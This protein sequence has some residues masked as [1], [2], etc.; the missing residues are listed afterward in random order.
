[1]RFAE[2]ISRHA[3]LIRWVAV[4]GLVGPNGMFLYVAATQPAQVLSA[5]QNPVSLAFVI[6]AVMLMALCTWLLAAT[7]ERS[8]PQG[9]GKSSPVSASVFVAAS[10]IGSLAFSVP[11]ALL[12]IARSAAEPS[13]D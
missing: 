2:I 11:L 13:S 8:G 9:D 7:A 1:M 6:E 5:L 10:V 3:V 12:R 4:V